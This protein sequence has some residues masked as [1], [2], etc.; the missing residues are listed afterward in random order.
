MRR[1]LRSNVSG[2]GIHQLPCFDNL[3]VVDGNLSVEQMFTDRQHTLVFQWGNAPCHTAMAVEAMF[4]NDD[5]RKIETIRVW[6]KN[7]VGEVKPIIC[8]EIKAT[9]FVL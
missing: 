9:L 6:M 2:L 1:R 5:R 7:Y 4:E 8:E 3:L